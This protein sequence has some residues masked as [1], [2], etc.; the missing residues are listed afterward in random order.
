ME[1][2]FAKSPKHVKVE[3]EKKRQ[4]SDISTFCIKSSRLLRTHSRVSTLPNKKS[5]LIFALEKYI[6]AVQIHFIL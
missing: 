3:R 4:K 5:A 2:N 6:N 1:G